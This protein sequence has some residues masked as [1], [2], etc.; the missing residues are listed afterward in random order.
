MRT[1]IFHASMQ[2]NGAMEVW[3]G[4]LL[5]VENE[6]QLAA[7]LAHEIAHYLE[8]HTLRKRDEL[9][10]RSA[11]VEAFG[12]V[13]RFAG[14][15]ARSLRAG[16]S[17]FNR[18]QEREADRLGLDLMHRAGYGAREA[19]KIWANLRQELEAGEEGDPN[20]RNPL[21]ATHP[22]A[23]ER[24]R[25]LGKIASTLTGGEINASGLGEAVAPHRAAWL[26]DEIQRGRPKETA[27]LMARLRS[28][29]PTLAHAL[30]AHEQSEQRPDEQPPG[31][32][33]AA[34]QAHI[35]AS[36]MASAPE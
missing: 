6:A 23:A 25:A 29:A 22:A 13:G 28:S 32:P 7:V 18:D 3:S 19:P 11:L 26:A 8:R 35:T 10:S 21:F 1:P 31:E 34:P 30:Q 36:R 33:E 16:M 20:R 24:E 15:G 9:K 17:A 4:L 27:A 14:L 2:A 12:I 5:R